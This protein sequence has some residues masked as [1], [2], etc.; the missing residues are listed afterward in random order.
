[1]Y[2]FCLFTFFAALRRGT[3]YT[4]TF[5][6]GSH[7]FYDCTGKWHSSFKGYMLRCVPIN[8]APNIGMCSSKAKLK[9]AS[10]TRYDTNAMRFCYT[11]RVISRNSIVRLIYT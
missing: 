11:P 9:R 3:F 8:I 10:Q 2:V 6:A 4:R 1:M 7:S 5:V